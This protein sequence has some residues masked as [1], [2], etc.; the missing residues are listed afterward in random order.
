MDPAGYCEALTRAAVRAG[1]RVAEE[2]PV[3]A[4]STQ[5]TLL[6]GRKVTEVHTKRGI[7]K[8]SAVVNAT[9]LFTYV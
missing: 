2:C 1:A 7:I 6:G 4:I 9:G 5:E 8:T 3:T